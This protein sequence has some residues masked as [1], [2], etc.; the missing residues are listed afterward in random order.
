MNLALECSGKINDPTCLKSWLES[1]GWV[2]FSK[3]G[4]V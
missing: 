1:P 2:P 3:H 4:L